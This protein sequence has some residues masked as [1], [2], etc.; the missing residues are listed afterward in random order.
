MASFQD[1]LKARLAAIDSRGTEQT[2]WEQMQAQRKRS[3]E[4]FQKR[5]EWQRSIS[6]RYAMAQ[7]NLANRDSGFSGG[8]VP[9]LS[10]GSNTGGGSAFD[11]FKASII[12][13]S[14]LFG[15]P[16]RC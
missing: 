16:T 14:P 7:Q 15:S 5:M 13:L 4:E 6:D 1:A 2:T 9:S 12:Y 8:G 11:K 3:E 10:G